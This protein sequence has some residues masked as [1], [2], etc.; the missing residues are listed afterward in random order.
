V[1]VDE[2]GRGW[3]IDFARVEKRHNL[4]DFIKLETYVRLMELARGGLAFSLCDYARFEKALNDAVLGKSVTPPNHPHLLFAY[5]VIRAIRDI[6]RKY[7][8]A[9]PDF[10]N[11]YFPA[12]FLYS[13]AVMKYYQVDTP[14]PTRLAFTTACVQAK[15]ILR[16]DDQARLTPRPP[17]VSSTPPR[18]EPSLGAGNR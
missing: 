8:G 6:A 14:Q 7:M 9:K 15:Y 17:M 3:L 10:R 11:E 2:W 5:E 16:I 13:L 18:P 4:F 12:L 1:L